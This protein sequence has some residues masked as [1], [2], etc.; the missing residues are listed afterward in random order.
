LVKTVGLAESPTN[1]NPSSVYRLEIENCSSLSK[2][3]VSRKIFNMK[4]VNCP[5]LYYFTTKYQIAHLK[6]EGSP[7]LRGMFGN[8]QIVCA[9]INERSQMFETDEENVWK[10]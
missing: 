4:V 2:I 7:Y 9:T 1:P 5:K 3:D 10:D 6:I 8:S